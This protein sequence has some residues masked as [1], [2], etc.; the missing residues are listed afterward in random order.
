MTAPIDSPLAAAGD[1]DAFRRALRGWLPKAIP[2]DWQERIRQGGEPAYVDVQREWYRA[3]ADA[4]LAT[5]HWPSAW[6]GADLSLDAQIV[7]YSELARADAPMAVMYVVA[8]Y[9]MPATMFAYGTPQ[10]RDRYLEG[11]RTGG[12]VWCQGFSEPGSGSDL[13]SLKTRAERRGDK[14]IVNGQKIWSSGGQNSD[15]CLLLA[16]TDSSSA[17]KQDGI[18]YFICDLRTPGIT[19][20]PISQP[21]TESEFNE[22]FFDDVEIPAENLIGAEGQ[23]WQ[24]AQT[25]LTTERG[26]LIFECV[27]RLAQAYIRDAAAGQDTWLADPIVAHE[28]ATF[29]PRIRGIQAMV[30]QLL[31]ELRDDPHGGGVMATYV[32]LYWGPLLQD[33]TLFLTRAQGLAAQVFVEPQRCAGHNSGDAFVDFMWSYG[34]TIAGGSNEV[35]RNIISERFLGLPKG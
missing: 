4:G 2:H 27:E 23:G 28:F 24:I 16:R 15:F 12:V 31:S 33:Y 18:S 20:R 26:L 9:H 22:I 5:A 17:R 7:F 35:M 11:V 29:Y 32:K 1:L 13:A 30:A 8:L 10:Q 14:Y 19:V 3:L 21:T 25:T 6:G 34:W